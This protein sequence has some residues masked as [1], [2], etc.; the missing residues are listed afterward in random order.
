MAPR[1]AA[2]RPAAGP[3]RLP[4]AA[5]RS[6][7]GEILLGA[8]TL[9]ATAA[10]VVGVPWLLLGAFG[11]P[12]PDEVP[13]QQ[14][15]TEQV[16]SGIVLHVFALVVW[17]AWLHFC[18]CLVVEAV[19]EVRGR[20]LAPRVPG[21]GVGTQAL[22]RRIVA[23]VLLLTG[24]G[25]VTVPAATA[26]VG[27]APQQTSVQRLEPQPTHAA[28]GHRTSPAAHAE[29]GS[30]SSA[31]TTDE[32]AVRYYKVQPPQ[33]RNYDTLWDIAERYLGSGL[34]YKEIA[35]LNRG[36]VQPDGSRLVNPDLIQPGWMLR[37]PADAEGVGLMVADTTDPDV[38]PRVAQPV[39]SLDVGSPQ[40]GDQ[41][42][43]AGDPTTVSAVTF[44]PAGGTTADPD[45]GLAEEWAPVFGTAGALLAAGLL[46]GLRRRTGWDR[47]P[48]GGGGLPLETELA[49]RGEADGPSAGLLDRSLRT[50]TAQWEEGEVPAPAQCAVSPGGIAVSF[51]AAPAVD[52]PAPWQSERDGRVWTMRRE[53][54]RRLP[55]TAGAL[56]P[57]PALV[58]AGR[59]A[60]DSLLLI[61][62]ESVAGV[63][64]LGGDHGVARDVA[65]SWAMEVATHA[66]ADRRRVTM[67]GF[68]DDMEAV[69]SDAVRRLDDLDRALE[70]IEATCRH[71]RQACAQLGADSVRTG[72][73]LRPDPRLWTN[74]L[75]VCSGV[76]DSDHMARLQA[77]AA[78]PQQA[79]S[80]VVVGDHHEAAARVVASPDG[81]L[82][83][84]PMGVD[85]KAQRLTVDASR[86]LVDLFTAEATT[87]TTGGP[88]DPRDPLSGVATGVV[89]PEVLDLSTRQPV[90]IGVLGPVAVEADGPFDEDRRDL[91]TEIV[92]YV[93]AH[94]E[95]VHPQV[96]ASAVWPRGVSDEVRDAAIRTAQ[97]WVGRTDE[98]A[99]RLGLVDGRWA[100]APQGVR[101]D[102]D[103]FRSLVNAAG[104]AG[105]DPLPLLDQALDLVRGDAW[106]DL[107]A[108]RY[109][110]LAH[111]GLESDVRVLV[112]AVA[113]R[114][115][116]LCDERD[117]RDGAWHALTR[118]QTMVPAA[119]ELWQDKLRLVAA[120]S[121][122]GAVREV[123]DAMYATLARHGSPLGASP[124]TDALVDEL[125]PGYRS[126]A[127]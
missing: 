33:N 78:D 73:A 69:A 81:R 26:V 105:A 22:A 85:V 87:D 41:V 127:A 115:A 49:L 45:A 125:L 112:V 24:T 38:A 86:G 101:F 42:H 29:Q 34:R 66:W 117:D 123:A 10:V 79:V 28:A 59:R 67:V 2:R 94:P 64:S 62:L 12:W 99:E 63:V 72:R 6:R 91:L 50:W 54:A 8:L 20:G 104:A 5:G 15:L 55:D 35:A 70:Q 114:L 21:G 113:S 92:L 31:A 111:S 25:A 23:L 17:L 1:T 96:L 83:C 58:T 71:Q 119:E 32:G 90:E 102:W 84:G 30:G 13:S 107:P 57:L 14:V 19:A 27:D 4:V 100:L 39:G 95:G 18:A 103:V 109:T 75:L 88:R 53:A 7:A 126:R 108:H 3:S 98:G 68:A 52:P 122:R 106:S 61:D 121:D 76:P 97:E 110:W 82:W 124:T 74:Q 11:Q 77:V 93:A 120:H 60:D 118:G 37:L 40:T 16:D 48:R 44:A 65:V 36:I 9:V 46:A 56:S 51:A 116:A 43:Q 47:G 89:D 80:V